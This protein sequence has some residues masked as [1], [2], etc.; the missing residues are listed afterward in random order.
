MAAGAGFQFH[1]SSSS[2]RLTVWPATRLPQNV[3]EVGKGL[4]LV[5]L[6]GLDQRGDDCPAPG[7]AAGTG[8]ES[9]FA[10]E[11]DGADRSFNGIGIEFD[12]AVVE[13]PGEAAPTAEHVADCLGEAAPAGD[14]PELFL[15]PR[16]EGSTIGWLRS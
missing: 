13:E 7:A 1:G 4:D 12:A 9:I 15:K 2:R 10:A 16:F 3:S 14:T 6:G 5:E 8:E 11:S